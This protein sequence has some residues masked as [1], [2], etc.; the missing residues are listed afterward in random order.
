[1]ATVMLAVVAILTVMLPSTG[2]CY[3][4][5]WYCQ[6]WHCHHSNKV[7]AGVK[8]TST[9]VTVVLSSINS[10]HYGNNCNHVVAVVNFSHGNNGAAA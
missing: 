10:C 7:I 1:M 6:V 2:C 8:V 5:N 4:G 9:V 3:H